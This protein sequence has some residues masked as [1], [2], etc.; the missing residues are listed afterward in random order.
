M[1]GTK[2][3][4]CTFSLSVAG[5]TEALGNPNLAIVLVHAVD[6]D[7]TQITATLLDWK[8]ADEDIA[9]LFLPTTPMADLGAFGKGF[10]Q[11]ICGADKPGV[12]KMTAKTSEQAVGSTALDANADPDA[13]A[14]ID[15]TITGEPANIALAADPPSIPCDGSTSSK[16]TA[17]VTDSDGNLVA[18]GVDVGFSAQ[19]LGTVS[20][21]K[22]DL[23]DGAASTTLTSVAPGSTGVP[24]VVT[25][26]DVQ[27]SILVNCTGA[28][29]PGAATPGAGGAG[30][31]GGRPT[32]TVRPP[33]TGSGGVGG[34]GTLTWWPALALTAAAGALITLRLAFARR[35]R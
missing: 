1:T 23:S 17:T 33:D 29:A 3:G 20:P 6:S 18:N 13:R 16:V 22:A 9:T 32:G 24:V 27:A 7:D 26:G 11:A 15:I 10:P 35:V 28:V 12:V 19:V 5:V 2:E 8:S 4:E 31:A 30:G 21:L 34:T 14:S 25:A